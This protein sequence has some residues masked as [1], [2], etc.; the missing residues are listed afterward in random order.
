MITVVLEGLVMI[1]DWR[2]EHPL[3]PGVGLLGC[4]ALLRLTYFSV[5]LY[6]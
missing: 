2:L 4:W 5:L 6:L 3:D 1:H